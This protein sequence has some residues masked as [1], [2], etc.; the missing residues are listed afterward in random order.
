MECGVEL[1][2]LIDTTSARVI[3]FKYFLGTVR[4]KE[5]QQVQTTVVQMMFKIVRIIQKSALRLFL[6]LTR[7]V[8]KNIQQSFHYC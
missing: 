3:S 5:Y 4:N 1:V 2:H 6:A 7:P 8:G